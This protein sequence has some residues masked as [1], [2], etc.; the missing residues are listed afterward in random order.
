M[1][2][3]PQAYKQQMTFRN[4]VRAGNIDNFDRKLSA[5]LSV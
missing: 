4:D 5:C 1:H 2:R 3:Q